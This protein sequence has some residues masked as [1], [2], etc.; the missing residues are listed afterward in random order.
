MIFDWNCRGNKLGGEETGTLCAA[1]AFA[2]VQS[3]SGG[4][5]SYNVND[6][7]CVGVT[8]LYYQGPGLAS[9]AGHLVRR[10]FLVLVGILSF[11]LA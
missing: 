4:A 7:N 3:G 9:N 2:S 10:L 8:T 6:F 5:Y 11:I 1:A